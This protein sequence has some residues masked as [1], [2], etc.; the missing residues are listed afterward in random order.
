MNTHTSRLRSALRR[1]V[2]FLAAPVVDHYAWFLGLTAL[3]SL[4][5]LVFLLFQAE[6]T[7]GERA[8]Q[9]L[10]AVA[11]NA[12]FAYILLG[13]HCTVFRRLRGQLFLKAMAAII[14]VLEVVNLFCFFTIHYVITGDIVAVIAATNTGE[15]QEFF[16]SY[17]SAPEWAGLAVCLALP[18][19]LIPLLRRLAAR[20]ARLF[21]SRGALALLAVCA[22]IAVRTHI[23]VGRS[24]SV[25]G[26]LHALSIYRPVTELTPTRPLLVQRQQTRIPTV[27]LI[28]GEAFSKNHSSLYGY[29]LPTNPLLGA[30]PDSLL[31]V[32]RQVES[33]YVSTIQSFSYFM[34]TSQASS[35]QERY[36]SANLVDIAHAAGYSFTWISNQCEKGLYDNG[37]SKFAHLCDTALW[38]GTRYISNAK[39]D[40][41]SD[42]LPLVASYPL[43]D[44]LN[45]V[46][47]HLMGSHE[48]FAERF[49]AEY[50]RFQP[51]EY[52]AYPEH[53]RATL[54]DYDNSVLFND[55]VV[56]SLLE[57]YA[58]RDAVVF[59]FSD[60]AMDIY[61][62]SP[63]YV[64]HA[65]TND[66]KSVHAGTQIPFMIYTSPAFRALHPVQT[67]LIE[68]S[69]GKPLNT[70][71]LP[72][73]VM[74]LMG[75][76]FQEQENE[77]PLGE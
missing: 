52:A 5:P 43:R 7:A 50:A 40:L 1:A 42:L 53:Q 13:L 25:P 22:L 26:I 24:Q 57:Q 14:Y 33:P 65:R 20:R 27:V 18:F 70:T 61:D 36:R 23:G 16:T 73:M 38:N 19:A 77:F 3:Q 2:D 21:T 76:T 41:D 35:L 30:M 67:A 28:V 56:S 29:A 8:S 68:Q 71:V 49:P 44:S 37:V 46:L 4:Y 6:G 72:Y 74:Q 66:P 39:R 9:A 55:Y 12:L 34:T 11:I 60:H 45:V 31:H 17:L 62:S 59:Y 32:F 51:S 10:S 69:V 64:G 75:V 54:A 58:G 47:I 63:T 15:A 48:H